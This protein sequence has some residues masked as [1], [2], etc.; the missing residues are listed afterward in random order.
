MIYNL[1]KYNNNWKTMKLNQLGTFAR[2]KSK[3]RPRNDKKLFEGGG[4]PLV[5]T[6]EIKEATLYVNKHST[7]YNEFGLSQSRLWNKDTLCITIAANI[8]ET[9]I[10]AYPM[11]FPDSIVGFNANKKESSELFMHYMFTYIKQAIQKSASGSIQDNIN[12]D[13]LEH[14]DFKIP[15][16]EVQDKITNILYNIDKKI[17]NNNKIVE[18]LEELS[19]TIYNYWFLQYEFPNEEG[20]PY[21]SFCGNMIWNENLNREI[22]KKWKVKKIGDIIL[23]RK[24]SSIQVGQ[25]KDIIGKYPFFTSGSEIY[26]SNE[27]LTE[28]RNCFL[29]TGGKGYVQYYVG[30]SAYS[31]DTWVISGIDGLEDYLYLFIKSMEKVLDNKYFAGTGLKHLQKDLF[32]DTYIVIPED[33]ILN[34]FNTLS[35]P[36]FDK[37]SKIYKEN[38]ELQKLRDFLLPLLMNGQVGF[39]N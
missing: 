39:K 3:H 7:E 24:K 36:I 25:A 5:Q 35:N 10:L 38:Q 17:E 14:L 34:K 13:Y 6:G 29:S 22:P 4:Y 32:K 15:S 1:T 8:A 33:E 11:C 28:G 19:K 26:E 12:I 37:V 18:T 16:K 27:V 23:E 20:K 21:K 30:K 9:A 31:T 2:G